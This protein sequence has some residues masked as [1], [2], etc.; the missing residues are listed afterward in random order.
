MKNSNAIFQ[1]RHNIYITLMA[2]EDGNL[3]I[4]PEYYEYIIKAFLKI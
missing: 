3:E 2:N 4:K 1:K